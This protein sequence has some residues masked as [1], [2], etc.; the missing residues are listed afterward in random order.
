MWSGWTSSLSPLFITCS[1]RI[2]STTAPLCQ[3]GCT[4]WRRPSS[5][6]KRANAPAV[7]MHTLPR[8]GIAHR[9]R[10]CRSRRKTRPKTLA[11]AAVAAAPV[12][13]LPSRPPNSHTCTRTHSGHSG[14]HAHAM[15]LLITRE[16]CGGGGG[17]GAVAQMVVVARWCKWKW[18]QWLWVQRWCTRSSGTRSSLGSSSLRRSTCHRTA[19]RRHI[20]PCREPPLG[21][22]APPNPPI[23]HTINAPTHRRTHTAT[24]RDGLCGGVMVNVVARWC[25]WW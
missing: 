22:Q 25:R 15:H 24:C 11:A 3:R 9:P 7:H 1:P 6:A 8:G 18:M 17:S 21:G 5:P 19:C 16:W 23:A 14:T 2:S 20:P 13:H 4:D 10:R 12:P